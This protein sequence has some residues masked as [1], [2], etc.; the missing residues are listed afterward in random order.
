[1]NKHLKCAI[2]VAFAPFVF[3]LTLVI[4]I[5][6]LP[7]ILFIW[8]SGC[9]DLDEYTPYTLLFPEWYSEL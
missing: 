1:M 3:L 4:T 8:I 2:K 9:V 7:L 5:I 6:E